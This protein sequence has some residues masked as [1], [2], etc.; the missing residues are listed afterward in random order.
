MISVQ[1]F[2]HERPPLGI[3]LSLHPLLPHLARQMNDA[4][5]VSTGDETGSGRL[6]LVAL[7][8]SPKCCVP[9]EF[10]LCLLSAFFN[11]HVR[12]SLER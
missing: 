5:D 4:A 9:G 12:G 8:L 11:V 10:A 7:S 1:S 3:S 2:W 6:L